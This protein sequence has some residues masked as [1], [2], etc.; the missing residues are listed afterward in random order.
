MLEPKWKIA[1]YD[2]GGMYAWRPNETL[3]LSCQE[4][5]H[6]AGNLLGAV[7]VALMLRSIDLAAEKIK[8]AGDDS[9]LGFR[10]VSVY[11]LHSLSSLCSE[12][13]VDD[14]LRPWVSRA[15]SCPPSRRPASTPATKLWTAC[16]QS[17]CTKT[18][19]GSRGWISSPQMHDRQEL[20]NDVGVLTVAADMPIVLGLDVSLTE[21]E[22]QGWDINRTRAVK[23]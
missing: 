13:R 15:T 9:F 11:P 5:L 22:Q 1:A 6:A 17:T 12:I 8:R 21:P 14:L 18:Q 10:T 16:L 23:M 3:A 20:Y 19:A 2:T 7:S 4:A